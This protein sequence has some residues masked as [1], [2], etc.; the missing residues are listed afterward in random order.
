LNTEI[1]DIEKTQADLITKC[2][3]GDH[4]A[5]KQLYFLYNKAMFNICV[6]MLNNRTDAE[7]VLQESFVSAFKNIG[8]FTGSSSFG[9]WLKSIVIH[10]SIDAIR[11]RNFNLVALDG[12]D[13]PEVDAEEE[14]SGDYSVEDIK[15]AMTLLPDGYR[16]ILDL[17]LF[18][19]FSH[20]MIA[21]KFGIS[22]GTSKSQYSRGKKRLL[23]LM[24]KNKQSHE[25]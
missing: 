14:E 17:F 15:K 16:V 12:K 23:E 3:K 8:Q 25:G 20:R 22:E 19:D 11:K 9:S 18:E 1:L 4:A 7:D 2:K 21:E 13:L 5:F 24:R 6:R 10:R